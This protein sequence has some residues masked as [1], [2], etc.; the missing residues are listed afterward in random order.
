MCVVKTLKSPPCEWP[1]NRST[2]NGC[3]SGGHISITA[4]YYCYYEIAIVQ[5][6]SKLSPSHTGMLLD[7]THNILLDQCIHLLAF[8]MSF[9]CHLITVRNNDVTASYCLAG[10]SL[11]QAKEGI[12]VYPLEL[13]SVSILVL[14]E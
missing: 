5:I 2:T 1:E 8:F 6:C 12:C 9:E 4:Q 11:R 3:L 10:I 13:S 14:Q 7:W